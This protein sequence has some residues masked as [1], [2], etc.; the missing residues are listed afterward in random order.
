MRRDQGSHTALRRS[1]LVS[2]FSPATFLA[3]ATLSPV[4]AGGLPQ[5]GAFVA[6]SGT[7]GAPSNGSLAISQWNHDPIFGFR[8]P[9]EV[10]GVDAKILNPRNTWADVDAYDVQ[11]KKLARMFRDNFKKFEPFVDDR[12]LRAAE[13]IAKAAD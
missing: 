13:Q 10:D 11:A 3:L 4:M 8:I 1:Y 9:V 2:V 5:G 6:G 7:I 12:V